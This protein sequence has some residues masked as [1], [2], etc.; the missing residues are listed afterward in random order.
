MFHL[1]N[2][3]V[4]GPLGLASSTWHDVFGAHPSAFHPFSR[5]SHIPLCDPSSGDR[6]SGC[7]TLVNSAA[8]RAHVRVCS[9]PCFPLLGE[10]FKGRVF[11]PRGHSPCEL[12]RRHRAACQ[13]GAPLC[14]FTAV[15]RVPVSPRPQRAALVILPGSDCGHPD[16]WQGEPRCSSGLRSPDD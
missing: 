9:S 14:V 4:W 8:V 16:G 3:T 1:W 11:V 6:H 2:H 12:S 7:R 10:M 5:L 15:T 13:G